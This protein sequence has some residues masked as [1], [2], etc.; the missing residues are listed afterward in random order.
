MSFE[1]TTIFTIGK[2]DYEV[3]DSELIKTAAFKLPENIL[4]D[5]DFLY[6]WLKAVSAGESW[7]SNKNSDWFP[8]HELENHYQTFLTAHV[9]KNHENKDIKNAIGDVLDSKWDKFM[10]CVKL[11]VRVDNKIAPSIVRGFQ[12][13]YM[14]DVSMGCR[15]EYSICSICGNKAKT[16]KEY[17]EHVRFERGKI[18][19]DGRKVYE[20]NIGPKFH[21]I[22]AVLNGAEKTA[23]VTGLYVPQSKIAGI[24]Q[25][26]L[27]KVASVNIDGIERPVNSLYTGMQKV[28][29]EINLSE[30]HEKTAGIDLIGNDLFLDK[31]LSKKAYAH[32]IA[33]LKKEI[34]SK[35]ESV[36]DKEVTDDLVEKGDSVR[37]LFRMVSENYWDDEKCSEISTILKQMSEERNVSKQE[38]FCQFIS[39]VSFTGCELAPK[40][41]NQ[42]FNNLFD[43]SQDEYTDEYSDE[44]E[45][46]FERAMEVPEL[47]NHSLETLISS[48]LKAINA[49]LPGQLG[50]GHPELPKH[51][52]G[53]TIMA[54]IPHKEHAFGSDIS[55]DLLQR[56]SSDLLGR[57]V[58]SP[59][60]IK[61]ASCKNN[62][63][64]F[65]K[66]PD[67]VVKQAAYM[68]YQCD[69]TKRFGNPALLK[70]TA[71]FIYGYVPMEKT[72][73]G[74]THLKAL[75]I[76]LP[77]TFGY[78][79]YQRSRIKNGENINSLNRYIAD[80]PASAYFIQAMF[81]PYAAKH[82]ANA[83]KGAGKA[84]KKG[85]WGAANATGKVKIADIVLGNMEKTASITIEP[86][87]QL[88][89]YDE[90]QVKVLET[91]KIM[92]KVGHDA[93]VSMILSKVGLDDSDLETYLHIQKNA[94][95]SDIT[96][97][98][99]KNA[100][101]MLSLDRIMPSFD[102]NRVVM[103]VFADNL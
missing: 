15:V 19:D 103:Q 50:S 6:M 21:D 29:S 76:G 55:R 45:E 28:A 72:A 53:V 48:A 49:D 98:L 46:D 16:P 27:A 36:S 79:A 92:S 2:D 62:N 32:K 44:K 95:A 66:M 54:I 75:T 26:G 80:N 4:Y 9:F 37:N 60:M 97:S 70:K 74:Y 83:I 100:Q 56:F 35:I 14:T 7:G 101:D 38:I 11:L 90:D 84:M 96:R 68:L 17:C 81:G 64:E 58:Y 71:D 77:V 61:K 25:S 30:T 52:R 13:G 82:G 20:I 78:S 86:V 63:E 22:S 18:Y 87:D 89:Q 8:R 85:Y 91:A 41:F 12:K 33:E 10:D 1:K 3:I 65:W 102:L 57:S 5:P 23:K 42:I 47:K 99:R 69:R 34:S 93:A 43:L 73:S 31:F 59:G 40:E 67:D 24:S 88:R 94:I 51:V 39:V